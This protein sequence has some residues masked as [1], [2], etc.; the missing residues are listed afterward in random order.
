MTIEEFKS[1]LQPELLEKVKAVC[2]KKENLTEADA[3]TLY[4]FFIEVAAPALGEDQVAEPFRYITSAVNG[5]RAKDLEAIIGEGF[6][7]EVFESLRTSLGFELLVTRSLGE[8]QLLYDFNFPPVRVMLQKLM[9]EGNYKACASDIGYYLLQHCDANDP[10]R[11]I[12]TMHLLLDGDEAAAA[13]EYISEVEG[14]P[15]RLA[16]LT[17]G[18][19]LK[20]GP[21][22]VQQCIFDLP[23]VQSEKVNLRK[24]LLLMLNDCVAIIGN[25]QRQHEVVMRLHE[26]I[27]GLIQNGEQDITVLLG[28]AKLRIAQNERIMAQLT[29]QQ[30]KEEEAKTHEQQAQQTFIGALNYLMPPLQQADPATISDEQIRQYWLCLKICQEMAQPKAITLIFEAIVKVE[31]A[32]IAAIAQKQAEKP[33]EISDEDSLRAEELGSRIIDQHIDLSKLYYQMPQPLQEQFTNYSEA[34]LSLISAYIEGIKANADRDEENDLGLQLRLCNYYQTI[35]E[36]QSHLGREEES[37]EAYTEAQIRQMRHLAAI[38]RQD[39]E[40]AQKEN[41]PGYM[42]QQ[43]LICRLTLSVTNHMLGMHYRKQNKTQHDLSILLRSNMDLAQDCFKAYPRDGR[44]IHFIINAAL[45]LG[46][47]QHK[48]KGLMAECGTYEKVIR[49]FGVLNNMRLDPQLIADMAM[50]HTKCGQVQCENSIRRF[51]DAQ[52][53]LSLALNLWTNLAQNTGNPEFKKNAEAVQ[54]MLNSIKR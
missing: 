45:E 15:L 41:K 11:A 33:E 10:V 12:Q 28:V 36:L 13:A 31:Q 50:I 54:K 42:S 14:E 18:N 25:P 3:K 23:L 16:T 5:L 34:A 32:Q 43:G 22:Y 29:H 52:R 1:S 27:G 17:L 38:K 6:N 40:T 47:M 49:Q 24:L 39:E 26:L 2:E 51:G 35:G 46:D 48:S 37:Y 44:V 53:N 19:G 8:D 9:S 21:E 30:K 4:D 20:D 7:A